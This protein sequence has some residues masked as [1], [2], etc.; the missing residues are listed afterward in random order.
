MNLATMIPR[1]DQ[2]KSTRVIVTRLCMEGSG[3][4]SACVSPGK[5]H[6]DRIFDQGET[7]AVPLTEEAQGSYISRLGPLHELFPG[8]LFGQF[9]II[10]APLDGQVFPR[11]HGSLHLDG[12]WM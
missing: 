9:E 10:D 8:Q 1:I 6:L 2:G 4:V 12:E 7:E 3:L 11:F 5:G